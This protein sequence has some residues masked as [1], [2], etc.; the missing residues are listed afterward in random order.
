MPWRL[1]KWSLHGGCEISVMLDLTN[2][3]M[4]CALHYFAAAELKKMAIQYANEKAEKAAKPQRQA[5]NANDCAAA[6]KSPESSKRKVR[7]AA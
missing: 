4:H 3:A 7:K 2:G 5:D 6:G 1:I